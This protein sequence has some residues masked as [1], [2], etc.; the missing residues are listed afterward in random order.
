MNLYV[1]ESDEVPPPKKKLWF[2]NFKWIHWQHK[3]YMRTWL[4]LVL[5]LHQQQNQSIKNNSKKSKILL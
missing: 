3:F 1:I 4:I 2:F 5:S